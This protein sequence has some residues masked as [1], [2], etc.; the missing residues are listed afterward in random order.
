MKGILSGIFPARLHDSILASLDKDNKAVVSG[1]G[2]PLSK[3]FFLH[4]LI[5]SIPLRPCLY[6]V[7]ND[8]EIP[9]LLAALSMFNGSLKVRVFSGLGNDLQKKRIEFMEN[10]GLFQPGSFIIVTVDFLFDLVPLPIHLPQDQYHITPGDRVI[11]KDLYGRLLEMGYR[12]SD[13]TQLVPGTYRMEGGSINIFPVHSIGPD[14]AFPRQYKIDLLDTVVEE[15]FT[16]DQSTKD[17]R[18]A[19][20]LLLYPVHFSQSEAPLLEY[21][22]DTTWIITDEVD[23]NHEEEFGQLESFLQKKGNYP[24]L[25]ITSFPDENDQYEHLRY[26]SVLKYYSITDFTNDLKEKFVAGWKV[27]IMTKNKEEI[28]NILDTYDLSYSFSPDY[29][30]EHS[31]GIILLPFEDEQTVPRSFQNTSLKIAVLT[32]REIFRI[33]KKSSLVEQK[34]VLDFLTSLKPGDYVVHND[35]GIGRFIG[36]DKK[37][38]DSITKEYIAIEYAGNDKLFI[39]TDQAGKVNRFIAGDDEKEPKL[40]RLDSGEWALVNRKVKKETEKIAKELLQLYAK[41]KLS[42]GYAFLPDTKEQNLFEETFLYEETPGQMKAIKDVKEDLEKEVPMDR[43]VCGDV[44]F[45]KTEV[46]LRAAFKAFVS[47]KQV[48]FISPVTI[49]TDQHYK[50]FVKRMKDFNVRI[51]MMSRFQS[52][53]EQKETLS[54]LAKGEVDIVIGTHRLLQPDVEFKNLGLVIVD[55]EQ[56]FGVKQK[57]KLKELRCNIHILTLTATPIPRTLNMSLNKLRDIT[58]ITTPPPGRLPIITEV[59]K[60]N[61]TLIRE[62]ILSEMKRQG[63]VYFLHNKVQ[64]IEGIADK[65]RFLI[66]EARFVVAHGQMDNKVLEERVM[67]FK[68]A[69]YD[70]LVSSTIIENGIDLPNANTLIVN[71][72]DQFGLSQL[73]QLRGRVGRSRKQAYTYLLYAGQR[74]SVDAKKRLRA[75]VEASELGSG[76]QIAMK[77]LEIRGAGDILG[78]N[79]HGVIKSVGVSHFVRMLNQTIEDM[80]A[81][82]YSD[83]IEVRPEENVTVELPLT[84]FIPE[85]FIPDYKEKIAIYQKMSSMDSLD[86]L[87]E[88]KQNLQ[89]EYGNLP[90]EVRNLFRVL[91][92]KL[93][94]KEANLLAVRI[95]SYTLQDKYLELHM[96]KRFTPYQVMNLLQNED[97]GNKWIISGDKLKIKL[98]DLGLDWYEGVKTALRNLVQGKDTKVMEERLKGNK[99]VKV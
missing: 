9:E 74:L 92:V 53:R 6:L 45:G 80:K 66:P 34:T 85:T 12:P 70:V 90:D 36:I 84:S 68:E 88:L 16:F 3:A 50:T 40:T 31:M 41:R 61:E 86:E 22:P 99:A 47:G 30:S 8:N 81:G 89:D 78:A 59:R 4:D 72:A 25:K 94:A 73:Y 1:V 14:D 26:L 95:V 97:N 38:I 23:L 10:K 21:V 37:T 27:V 77:D 62:A 67:D 54:S 87:R 93:L 58:T 52:P 64:T 75:I 28:A 17:Y 79:Q 96:S 82:T 18:K 20:Q 42:K 13:D 48:A 57:E 2:A 35:H 65:L 91:E 44:G 98:K 51:A 60:Y 5:F 19:D 71:N 33:K 46:A 55:E 69:K 43:L 24:H 83:E 7:N 15:I 32:D 63:Q 49:L 11:L 56:K 29:F 76:F 39:P